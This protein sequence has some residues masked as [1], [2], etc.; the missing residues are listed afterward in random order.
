MWGKISG[1]HF[2]KRHKH[3][4]KDT[5]VVCELSAQ[6]ASLV[7]VVY[8]SYNQV[9]SSSKYS[10]TSLTTRQCTKKSTGH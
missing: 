5:A 3:I 2:C 9:T 6:A 8:G 7:S 4:E 1:W 10:S